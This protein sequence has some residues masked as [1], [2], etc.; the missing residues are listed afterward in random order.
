MNTVNVNLVIQTVPVFGEALDN[1]TLTLPKTIEQKY[2][3]YSPF[4]FFLLEQRVSTVMGG[5]LGPD[6]HSGLELRGSNQRSVTLETEVEVKEILEP[7]KFRQSGKELTR[8]SGEEGWLMLR[9]RSTK[10]SQ[11]K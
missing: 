4:P 2:I 11:G 3:S 9:S 1:K 8:L 6:W 5:A 7:D 10:L